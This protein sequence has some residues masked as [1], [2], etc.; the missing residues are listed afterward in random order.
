MGWYGPRAFA[1]CPCCAHATPCYPCDLDGQ[2]TD[3]YRVVIPSGDFGAGTYTLSKT[4]YFGQQCHYAVAVE[5]DCSTGT[6]YWLTMQ[7]ATRAQWFG[8]EFRAEIWWVNSITAGTLSSM[9]PQYVAY[10]TGYPDCS[11][12]SNLSLSYIYTTFA[13][14]V[15]IGSALVTAL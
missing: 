6:T 13:C 7:F 12:F 9:T 8:V 1:D 11:A 4:S 2:P 14:G 3:T 15:T 5:L 10:I